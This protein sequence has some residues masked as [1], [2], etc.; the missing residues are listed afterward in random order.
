[1]KDALFL[2]SL[3]VLSGL[4]NALGRF[5]SDTRQELCSA[6]LEIRRTQEWLNERVYHW[7]RE[8]EYALAQARHVEDALRA[9]ERSS[10]RYDDCYAA[11]RA[12]SDAI[13][14]LHKCQ[15]ELQK[16]QA[17]RSRVEQAIGAYEQ[18]ARRVHTLVEVHTEQARTRLSQLADKYA[19]VQE[20]ANAVGS[21]SSSGGLVSTLVESGLITPGRTMADAL[22]AGILDHLGSSGALPT[23]SIQMVDLN[24]LPETEDFSIVEGFSKTSEAEMC[25]GLE[26]WWTEMR[27][28]IESGEGANSDYWREVDHQKGLTFAEGY[29]RV[30]EALYGQDSIHVDKNGAVYDIINGR[31]RIWLARRIGI[32]HLPMQ[33]VEVTRGTLE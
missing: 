4:Q 20:S 21:V 18:Q 17:W 29:Q 9:C 24:A 16:T 26:R 3:S 25:A 11:R 15:A 33:V 28:V 8:V 31:H 10:E 1:M 7:Q 32:P 23:H 2:R 22:T 13:A 27:P 19:Q 12:L 6:E 30:Y 14:Y 5:A